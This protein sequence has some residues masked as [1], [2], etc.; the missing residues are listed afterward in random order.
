VVNVIFRIV[1]GFNWPLDGL[2][3]AEIPDNHSHQVKSIESYPEIILPTGAALTALQFKWPHIRTVRHFPS[4]V[5]HTC[6]SYE[7]PNDGLE[8]QQHEYL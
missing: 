7:L 8:T 3:Q 2:L 4:L 1:S 6:G 5:I